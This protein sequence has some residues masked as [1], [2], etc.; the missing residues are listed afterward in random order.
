MKFFLSLVALVASATAFQMASGTTSRTALWAASLSETNQQVTGRARTD[1]RFFIS[2]VVLDW[3]KHD[4]DEPVPNSV[5]EKQLRD[6]LVYQRARI[7]WLSDAIKEGKSRA[8]VLPK[9]HE[10]DSKYHLS[11]NLELWSVGQA[12]SCSS[13]K[14]ES[15]TAELARHHRE[16]S[17]LEARIAQLSL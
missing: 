4:N 10:T 6:D 1:L 3:Y 15:L 12:P 16:V 8:D 2:K 7:T 17:Q 11:P 13:G 5:Q 9:Y 14:D